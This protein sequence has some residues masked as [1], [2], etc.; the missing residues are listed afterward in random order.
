MK[1]G[2]ADSGCTDLLMDKSVN[3]Y[4]LNS[5]PA[6]TKYSM[7]DSKFLVAELKGIL[8]VSILNIGCE[9]SCE[10]WTDLDVQ[11]TTADTGGNNLWHS[12]TRPH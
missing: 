10:P 7:A 11:V 5:R 6:N 1:T 8:Q 9:P 4:L 2:I 12:G 3:K